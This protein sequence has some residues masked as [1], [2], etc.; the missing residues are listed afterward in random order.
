MSGWRPFSRLRVRI[1]Q[2]RRV[3]LDIAVT[4]VR[5]GCR[6][7]GLPAF[8]L[9]FS[10]REMGEHME[11]KLLAFVG[12]LNREAP[13]FQGARGNGLAVY[14]FD[15]G[16]L[17]A[18]LICETDSVDN[19]TFLSVSAD[20]SR[21]YANSEVFAWR[22]GL[23]T[24]FAFDR[25]RRELQHINMRSSLGSIT[26]HNMMTH[27]GSKLLVANYA[28][29]EGGPDQSLVVYGIREDGGLSEPLA[30]VAHH[31]SGPN[32]ERQERSHAHSFTQLP[33]SG[34][35][36]ACDLGLD[37]LISYRIG[38]DGGLKCLANLA[39]P[40]GSGP[41][42]LAVDPTGRFGF[43]TNELDSTISSVRL[44]AASGQ[45]ELLDTQPTVPAGARDGNHCA[46]IQI[47]P[48]GRFIYASNRGHDSIVIHAADPQTGKLRLVGHVPCGG[49]TP[50]KITLTPSG[51]TLWSANQ[52]GDCIA[53]FRRDPDSGML[54]DTGRSIEIGTPMCIRFAR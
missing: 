33:K 40:A 42:H 37:R 52:N 16:T 30:S 8:C 43:V 20:G 5:S 29:G 51:N 38:S 2:L 19:P 50:R 22:E 9:Y 45:M 4:D 17:E 1:V 53:I 12:C 49:A 47:S 34:L 31:G 36:I 44:N 18:E 13:Y 21:V 46:D 41:R 15:E 14:S 11:S 27:D 3:T 24:A 28:M 54:S 26:A 6:V 25:A 48:E 23:V 32:K 7:S 35:A 10:Q 39:M